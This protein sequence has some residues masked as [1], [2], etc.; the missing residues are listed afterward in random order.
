M[1][2]R[3]KRKKKQVAAKVVNPNTATPMRR[4]KRMTRRTKRRRTRMTRTRRKTAAKVGTKT[5]P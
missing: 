3:D 5:N 1:V 2:T 4:M